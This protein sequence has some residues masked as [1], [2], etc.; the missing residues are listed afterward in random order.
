MSK[1]YIPSLDGIRAI[2]FLLVFVAH[3]GLDIVVPGGMGVTVFFFLS[4]FLITT[5]LRQEAAKTYTLSF[6]TFYLRRA[7]RILPPMFVTLALCYLLGAFGLLLYPGNFLGIVSATAYFYNYA[8]LFK[9]HALLPTGSEVLWSLMVEEHFYFV[10][11]LVY[12]F[13]IRRRIPRPTQAALLLGLC[14]ADLLWRCILVFLFHTSLD[15]GHRWTYIASDARFDSILFGCVLAIRDNPWLGDPSPTLQRFKG[16]FAVAGTLLLLASLLVR[17]PHFRETLRYS[18]QG[19]ALY[20]LFYFCIATSDQGPARWLEWLP[21]RWLGWV[22]YSLYLI[23]LTL[24]GIGTHF[25]PGHPLA[26]PVAAFAL[27]LAYAW[28]MRHAIEEPSRRLRARIE[29]IGLRAALQPR[30]AQS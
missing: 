7:F 17:E 16:R 28:F 26:V 30:T 1:A 14:F 9:L 24:L 10:F 23:H 22:S 13:F 18:L 25:F 2:A 11:P 12:L 19:I 4:G 29:R 27:S 8:E 6:R 3:A 21:L 5:I 15:N 20:F